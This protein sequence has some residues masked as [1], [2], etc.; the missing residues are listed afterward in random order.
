MP[1]P[2]RGHSTTTYRS[3]GLLV[4]E[5][6][7]SGQ[8]PK[9]FAAGL[10]PNSRNYQ[11]F[12]LIIGDHDT[13]VWVTNWRGFRSLDL[14]PGIYGLSNGELD[15]NW[16]K[17]QTGKSAFS[18]A[19]TGLS[20]REWASP[21]FDVLADRSHPDDEDLPATN[22]PHQ[23]EK[24]VGPRFVQGGIYGTRSSTVLV[25]PVSGRPRFA[26]RRFSWFGRA[27]GETVLDV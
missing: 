14:E 2:S 3:R 19:L 11:P 26:E 4:S 1:L 10:E 5:Y 22:V 25:I 27:I 7:E 18:T 20:S 6:L 8:T 21:I 13:L 16:P 12:N 23:V 24:L 17:V 15:S 9:Q